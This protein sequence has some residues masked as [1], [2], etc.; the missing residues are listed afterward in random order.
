MAEIKSERYDVVSFTFF[1]D[2]K[3]F[4]YLRQ[5]RGFLPYRKMKSKK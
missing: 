4:V 5:K 1:E 3:Y 2:K